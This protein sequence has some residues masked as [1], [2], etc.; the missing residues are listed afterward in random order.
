MS[1][2]DKAPQA[3]QPAHQSG[4]DNAYYGTL[5]SLTQQD[6]A[7][8]ATANAGYNSAYQG[9]VNNPYDASMLAGIN[10]AA[11][12]TAGVGASDLASGAAATGAAGQGYADANTARG[13]AAPM[14]ADANTLRAYAPILA[15]L[16]LD[17]NSANFNFGMQQTQDTQNVQNAEQGVAGSPF[18]AGATGDA[19]AAY[20]RNYDAS[21]MSKAMQALTALSSLYQGASGLDANAIG[22]LS[23]AGGMDTNAAGLATTGS[24]LSHT[25]AQAEATAAVMPYTASNQIQTDRIGALDS[26]VQGNSTAGSAGRGDVQGYG[27]YMSIGQ[28]ATG[29]DQNAAKINAQ[30]SFMGQLGALIGTIGP[31]A[32]KAIAAQGV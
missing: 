27:N 21:R 25:G 29:L 18:A 23:S 8:Q 7:V 26:M 17:P 16:G 24:N 20:S 6:T 10:S 14:T 11:Q 22:A 12:T 9:V 31:A 13:L 2:G 4:A 5:G 1:G 32:I 19:M 28:G 15:Q 3:Y 30:N